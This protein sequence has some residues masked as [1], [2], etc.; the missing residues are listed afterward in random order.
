MSTPDFSALGPNS[1]F[2]KDQYE[3]FLD[4]PT[5]V[6]EPWRMFFSSINGS[7][8]QPSNQS[9]SLNGAFGE[10]TSDLSAELKALSITQAYRNWGHLEANINPLSTGYTLPM[11]PELSTNY[12]NISEDD[13][14]K[15]VT[16][17]DGTSKT[18]L[19]ALIKS[20]KGIYCRSIGFE[21]LHL[22]SP[23]ERSFLRS[24]IEGERRSFSVEERK[25]ALK[26]LIEAEHLE[27]EIHK[28]YVGQKRFSVEGGEATVAM[29]QT[30][31]DGCC[32]SGVR[33]TLI[34]MA[35]RGR[36]NVLVNIA[37]KPLR[38]LFSE[39]EDRTPYSSFGGGDVKYH[40]GYKSEVTTPSGETVIV[41]VVPNPSHLEAVNPVV[42]GIARARQDRTYNGDRSSVLPVLIHGDA[43]M[44]GQGIVYET[45]NFA[46]VAGYDT[47]G[48]IHLIIN[49][50]VGFTATPEEGRS[51]T[52][53]SD[54]AKIY[55]SPVFHVNGEDIEACL[56]TM[57]LA[58]EFRNEFK[59]DVTIDLYC[60]R[61]YGHNEGDDPSFTQ[62]RMYEEIK[63]KKTVA[64]L[65]AEALIGEGVLTEEEYQG[66]RSDFKAHFKSEG[67]H[68][69]ILPGPASPLYGKLKGKVPNTAV[70][71]KRL[72]EIAKVITSHPEDFDPHPKLTKIIEKRT[73]A[74]FEGE[75]AEWGL[76]E[77]LAYG[78]LIQDGIKIRISG[79]DAGR[80]TFSHRHLALD[81]F[82]GSGVHFP[83]RSIAG[84]SF[85]EVYNSPLSEYGVLG[86]EFGYAAE[87]SDAL[88]IWEAQFGDFS[89]GAQIV[90]DQFLSA[91]ESKWGQYSG[92][93]LL[94]PHAYEG[95][96]PE[97][98]SARLERYLQL[99]A[100]DNMAVCYPTTSAQYFHMIRRQALSEIKRPLIVMSPKSLLRHAE[101]SSKLEEFTSHGFNAVI[102]DSIGKGKK[103]VDTIV[104]L[105]GKVFYDVSAKLKTF[106]GGKVRVLRFEELYPF[107]KASL[108]AAI[109]S[110]LPK[111]VI[112]LQEEPEN[113]GAYRY[114]APNL[115][116]A[117]GV[118]VR[119]IGRPASGSTAAGSPRRHTSEQTKIL[120]DLIREIGQ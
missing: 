117:I 72:K 116:D 102:V 5:L 93:T 30:L 75:G 32:R 16:S 27:S 92:V 46:R 1:G 106:E 28:R 61:K 97:H 66:Y 49:N 112:W 6:S 79:Q 64:V 43:A 38:Y 40:L 103:E 62:P 84:D 15:E 109:G 18:T 95:Q 96:G 101:A 70:P 22:T 31:I 80:G 60:Y 76:G 45:L 4:D 68:L 8:R 120:E 83:L 63:A 20:L 100:E 114:I 58:L 53:C 71:E 23:E 78:S 90:A 110:K 82:S 7:Y 35:H 41:R 108:L 17:L 107:P 85:F 89:N 56:E 73:K 37:G 77:A 9:V 14:S 81:S 98:S 54:V 12:H 25:R 111:R 115:K 74:L 50:Q 51:S 39:F 67:D 88:V 2:I 24:R 26:K 21:Y 42:E 86:F 57:L 10:V 105:S 36:L 55:E 99:C 65:Y 113:M 33:E 11:T 44:S 118:E 19:G 91:S 119:Y 13:Q 34:G 29:L 94:L 87:A 47:G 52:Y 3:L 104:C 48:T 69:P 59:R